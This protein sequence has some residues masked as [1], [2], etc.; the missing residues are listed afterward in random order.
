MKRPISILFGL[1]L[2]SVTCVSVEASIS[3]H[4]IHQSNAPISFEQVKH[5]QSAGHR[6][7]VM[8][9]EDTTTLTTTKTVIKEKIKTND[10]QGNKTTTKTKTKTIAETTTSTGGGNDSGSGSTDS[11]GDSHGSGG[12]SYEGQ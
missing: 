5:D 10:G 6:A 11:G 4:A 12:A 1:S 8:L 9:C 2:F 7:G 3:D